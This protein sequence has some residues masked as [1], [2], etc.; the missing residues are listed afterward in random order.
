MVECKT[1]FYSARKTSLCERALKKAEEKIAEIETR[2]ETLKAEQQL[3]ENLAD[4]QK[5]SDLQEKIDALEEELLEN[6]ELWEGLA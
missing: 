4:Y 5:L 3:P 6:M 2:L 1:V